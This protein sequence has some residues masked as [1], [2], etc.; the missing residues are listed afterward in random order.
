MMKLMNEMVK[1]KWILN[2]ILLTF[3]LLEW[4][5]ASKMLTEIGMLHVGILVL[6][7][8]HINYMVIFISTVNKLF[9]VIYVFTI[10]KILSSKYD[11]LL[12]L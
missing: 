12:Y 7:K 1:M 10:K 11:K 3:S 5:F 8:E 9:T 6:K 2:I 4:S